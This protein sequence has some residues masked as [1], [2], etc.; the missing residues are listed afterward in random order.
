[1]DAA[2]PADKLPISISIVTGR[3]HRPVTGGDTT[4][5][6]VPPRFY[7]DT[8]ELGPELDIGPALSMRSLS[9]FLRD[10]AERQASDLGDELHHAEFVVTRDPDVVQAKGVLDDHRGCPE[11][12][13]GLAA[14]LKYMLGHPDT[15]ML[16]GQLFWAG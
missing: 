15:D 13:D 8:S 12:E 3:E 9:S 14:A 1:M 5:L 10:L 6:A 11:C 4:I 7:I 16:V 2:L